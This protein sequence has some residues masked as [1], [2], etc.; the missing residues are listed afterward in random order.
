MIFNFKTAEGVK[1]PAVTADQMRQIDRLSAS[2]PGPNLWQMMENAG[3]N[4]AL[5]AMEMLK[6][7]RAQ[8]ICVVLA[9]NG[10][11][12]GGG[13]CAARHLANRGANVLLLISKPIEENSLV[14]R[15]Y[16]IYQTAGGM[17]LTLEDF[18]EV[19]PDLIIDALIG[20][21]LKG[22]LR[23]PEKS[24]VHWANQ[25]RGQR[26]SLDIPS[27]LDA[28]DGS[29]ADEFFE[30][31]VTMTLALPKTGL[32]PDTCGR[33]ILADIGIPPAL[34]KKLGLEVPVEVFGPRFRVEI[35]PA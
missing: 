3:R 8:A 27:G 34:Y 12:G 35:T 20:Y 13:I 17:T 33:L 24:L 26:L 18:L 31:N 22:A 19:Q 16:H 30:A 5:T 10:G 32:S 11:N 9:G 4:L 15:Q 14:Q 21:G 1:V 25:C 23:E 2:G 28:T 29:A 6:S 7:C